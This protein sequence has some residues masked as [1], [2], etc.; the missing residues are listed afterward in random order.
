[1]IAAYAPFCEVFECW[2]TRQLEDF[3]KSLTA[4]ALR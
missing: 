2:T 3:V 1:V 4:A